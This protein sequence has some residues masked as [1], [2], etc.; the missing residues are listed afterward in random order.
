M[1]TTSSA[2][3]AASTSVAGTSWTSLGCYPDPNSP[4][5]LNNGIHTSTSTNSVSTCLTTCKNAGY[6]YAG[7]EYGVRAA[8][9]H[10]PRHFMII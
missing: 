3:S 7:V 8:Y 9:F 4:R 10:P 6:I 1:T 2:S 5:T